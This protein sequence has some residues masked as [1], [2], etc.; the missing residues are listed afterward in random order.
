MMMM[1][2]FYTTKGE[3]HILDRQA[4]KESHHKM[5]F[6]KRW[7]RRRWWKREDEED[8][9]R[10]KRMKIYSL[11]SKILQVFFF[12][13][14]FYLQ[15]FIFLFVFVSL[16]KRRKRWRRGR[17]KIYK[18]SFPHYFW[19]IKEVQV[20]LVKRKRNRNQIKILPTRRVREKWK[21]NNFHQFLS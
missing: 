10:V 9:R 15:I 21:I 2:Y 3:N 20:N 1:I 13:L 19:L 14:N 17:K 12:C 5:F 11:A 7:R 6:M 8:E 4:K 18:Q 16:L